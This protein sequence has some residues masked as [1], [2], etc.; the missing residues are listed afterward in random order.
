MTK[1]R[2]RLETPDFLD[3]APVR[4]TVRG[5]LPCA[6][7]RLFEVFEDPA[8]WDAWAGAK[9]TW[10][11]PRP[12]GVGTT[13]TVGLGPITA[14]EEFLI[15]DAGERLTFHFVAAS[16]PCF[17]AFVEDYRVRDL[18]GGRCALEWS[19]AFELNGRA[20]QLGPLLG[21]AMKLGCQGALLR[22]KRY[23]R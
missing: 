7:R 21:P 1:H 11:S 22:L 2:L 9:V 13:R 18:G 5:T 15:W 16:S 8:A 3:R 23:V 14:Y 4:F 12:F 19:M 20:S 10:T 17:A 6:P